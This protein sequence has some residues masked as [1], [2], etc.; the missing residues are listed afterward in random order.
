MKPYYESAGIT[1]YH[2]DALEILDGGAFSGEPIITDPPYGVGVKY[3]GSYD[4]SRAD[5]WDWARRW[6][7]L[8][9]AGRL[10]AFTHRVTAL[11]ELKGWDWVAVWNKPGAFGARIGNSPILPHWEPIFLYGIHTLGTRTEMLADVLTINPEPARAGNGGMGREKWKNPEQKRHPCPK[12]IDLYARLIRC[13]TA[14]SA[15]V[16]D[17]F[18]GLGTTLRAA[19]D[20]GRKAIGIDQSERYCEIAAERLSQEV[21]D[22]S[23]GRSAQPHD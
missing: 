16:I 4:D 21:L 11:R 9:S 22:F 19:K 13:L 12:P 17:P 14:E 3:A 5:Y 2:G 6:V 7:S 20:M 8:F 1:I 18:C 23:A 15:I 10:M